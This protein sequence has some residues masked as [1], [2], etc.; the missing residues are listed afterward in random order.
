MNKIYKVVR[1]HATGQSIVVSELAKGQGKTKVNAKGIR[2]PFKATLALV[3]GSAGSAWAAC[4]PMGVGEINCFGAGEAYVA[5]DGD[6]F[7]RLRVNATTGNGSIELNNNTFTN[8]TTA[9]PIVT[10]GVSAVA[11]NVSINV[12][13]DNTLT[14][15]DSGSTSLWAVANGGGEARITVGQDAILNISNLNPGSNTGDGIEVSGSSGYV[16]HLGSG[17]VTVYG[18]H[19]VFATAT[20]VNGV[21]DVKLGKNVVIETQGNGNNGIDAHTS[22]TGTIKVVTDAQITTSGDNAKG[23]F[24]DALTNND[25]IAI[26]NT[27]NIST[28]GRFSDGI[29]VAPLAGLSGSGKIAVNNS[30]NITT[31]NTGVPIGGRGAHAIYTLID[32][33][34]TASQGIDINQTGGTLSTTGY[35]SHGILALSDAAS[36]D[37]NITVSDTIIDVKHRNS[38]AIDV[39]RQSSGNIND[40]SHVNINVTTNGGEFKVLDSTVAPSGGANYGIVAIQYDAAAGDIR[41]TN[42]GTKISTGVGADGTG[43]NSDAISAHFMNNTATGNISIMNNGKLSTQAANASTIKAVNN[44]SGSI[45]IINKEYLSVIGNDASAIKA[46]SAGSGDI[47]IHH[48]KGASITSTGNT[49]AGSRTD[50]I[51]GYKSNTATG[52]ITIYVDGDISTNATNRGAAAYAQHQGVGNAT[53]IGTGNITASASYA[54]TNLYSYGLAA[55]V[56]DGG[57]GTPAAGNATVGYSQGTIRTAGE[58]AFALYAG[59]VGQYGNTRVENSGTLETTGNSSHGIWARNETTDPASVTNGNTVVINTG[60]IA[61]SGN[62]ASGIYGNSTHTLGIYNS[63]SITTNGSDPLAN[64]HG[65]SGAIQ[66]GGKMDITNDGTIHIKGNSSRGI[67]ASGADGA[68][69]TVTNNG[70]I[71]H[72]AATAHQYGIEVLGGDNTTK[73]INNNGTIR[74]GNFGIVAW[75]GFGAHTGGKS[76]VNIGSQ[77]VVDAG[78]GITVDMS[79][80][81][82]INIANGGRVNGKTYALFLRSDGVATPTDT[83]NNAGTITSNQDFALATAFAGA[84]ATINLNNL[85]SGQM[86]GVVTINRASTVHIENE[87]Q[88]NLRKF[89]DTNADGVRVNK[90]IAV[91]DF[92]V[93]GTNSVTNASSGTLR[94]SK[95]NGN[96]NTPS[97]VGEYIPVGALSITNAGT[98]HGQLLNLNTFVNKGKIDL[99]DN[100]QAGDVLVISGNTVAGV[101]NAATANTYVSDG[102]SVHLDSVMNKGGSISQSDILVLDDVT[103]GG[104]GATK[105]HINAVG[106]S[107]ALTEGDGIKII[108]VLGTQSAGAFA[109]AAPITYG[110]YEYVLAQGTGANA[111]NWFLQNAIR[112]NGSTTALISPVVGAYLGNQYAAGH[113]FTQSIVDRRDAVWAPDS[114]AWMRVN[115]NKTEMDTINGSQSTEIKGTMIQLGADVGRWGDT[116]LGVF[117]GYGNSKINNESKATG[118]QADGKVDGY[119]LGVYGSW[120]PEASDNLY[121]DLWGQYAWFDNKLTG[122]AQQG[123]DIK[124]DSSA[125]TLS[126][127][128]GYGFQVAQSENLNWMLE[129]HAQVTYTFF[130]T[131]DFTDANNT[132]FSDGSGDGFR[133]RLGARLYGTGKTG[134]GVSP[135]IETNWL[136]DATD[137]KVSLLGQHNAKADNAKDLAEVKLGF[138][139]HFNQNLSAWVHVGGQW[140]NKNFTRYEGQIGLGYKW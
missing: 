75:N 54:G 39:Q 60:D 74:G 127:E 122:A 78:N 101:Y 84:G 124:Y 3:L 10:V 53:V 131:D 73:I 103:I 121:V 111:N 46:T 32:N 1:C 138:E 82:T 47:V 26:V 15:V 8:T 51:H 136:H 87:G 58:Q 98:V 68:T 2:L 20:G 104:G 22:S 62:T 61:T 34:G 105:V 33:N 45:D 90:E 83:V 88:W 114:S 38:D 126:A 16:E 14:A 134:V 85:S 108:E 52:D 128:V 91:S 109:T 139:G 42:N 43:A 13:G 41:I 123:Q 29:I 37:I 94:L 28:T 110:L 24:A 129:P 31:S 76:I 17:K 112:K 135:F 57:G 19:G 69:I 11:G 27:G 64:A 140:G 65:I 113:M 89:T 9:P 86:T 71:R 40:V 44:G 137:N 25:G 72:D 100:Q 77:G 92:G 70:E 80:E 130:S 21:A 56:S 7:T 102:G 120:I 4:A 50:A 106:G 79:D 99:T 66:A 107:G 55:T 132:R 6:S 63:A 35:D 118:S 36:G 117:G 18:G 133:S 93:G 116:R 49:V 119:H 97:T 95:A 48:A 12:K 67:L 96:T 115:H 23:I 81:N 5:N 125:I 30:G 59:V